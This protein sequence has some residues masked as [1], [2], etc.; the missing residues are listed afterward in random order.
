MGTDI[1]EGATVG[2]FFLFFLFCSDVGS[3]LCSVLIGQYCSEEETRD[4][5]SAMIHLQGEIL[6]TTF[7][8]PLILKLQPLAPARPTKHTD[9]IPFPAIGLSL[10]LNS[11]LTPILEISA[12]Y[13]VGNS[14]KHDSRQE[15]SVLQWP[16]KKMEGT[17]CLISISLPQK[18]LVVTI[19]IMLQHPLL[20]LMCVKLLKTALGRTEG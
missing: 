10:L 5:T 13:V 15:P 6:N 18:M 11:L 20:H 14:S 8:K 17:I 19:L 1:E 2:F 12:F 7:T 9:I 16:F 3:K 4:L